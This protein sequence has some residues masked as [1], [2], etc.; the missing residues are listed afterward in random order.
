LLPNEKLPE[1]SNQKQKDNRMKQMRK[2]E[3]T[4]NQSF[5]QVYVP[6]L[7]ERTPLGKLIKNG[8]ISSQQF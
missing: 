8:S 5:Q 4:S 3:L 7:N 2:S 6:F 1:R